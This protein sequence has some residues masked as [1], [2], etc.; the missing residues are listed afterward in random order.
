MKTNRIIAI[1]CA[2]SMA[3]AMTACGKAKESDT[4]NSSKSETTT[5]ASADES[6]TESTDST[7]SAVESNVSD[8]SEDPSESISDNDESDTIYVRKGG[9]VYYLPSDFVV[10]DADDTTSTLYYEAPDGSSITYTIYYIPSPFSKLDEET[11]KSTVQSKI[12]GYMKYAEKETKYIPTE[13]KQNTILGRTE[14]EMGYII[15][16]PS[17]ENVDYLFYSFIENPDDENINFIIQAFSFK[18]HEIDY[19][20]INENLKTIYSIEED[21]FFDD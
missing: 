4:D 2:A 10:V 19:D 16:G 3:L 17:A 11:F 7:E 8:L 9:L 18:D 13:I 21:T 6:K 14:Y 5:K 12:E 15:D 1:L 20:F